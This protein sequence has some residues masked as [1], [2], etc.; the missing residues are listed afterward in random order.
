M[1]VQEIKEMS[2]G[3]DDFN[4]DSLPKWMGDILAIILSIGMLLSIPALV[5]MMFMVASSCTWS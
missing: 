3:A 5:I 4:F 1:A 2:E